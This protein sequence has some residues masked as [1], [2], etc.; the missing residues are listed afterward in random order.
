[1][2]GWGC[3]HENSGAC[4]RLHKPCDPGMRGCI[5]HG[6]FTFANP[7][8]NRRRPSEDDEDAGS[9]EARQDT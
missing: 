9:A 2:S 4:E 5:L 3:P 8:K 1:M 6:R 7:D